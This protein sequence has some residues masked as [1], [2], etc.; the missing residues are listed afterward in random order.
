MYLYILYSP[1]LNRYYKGVSDHPEQ[2]LVE[3][4]TAI[5][6]SAYTAAASDWEL[7]FQLK[8]ENKTQALKIERYLKKSAN[9]NYLKRF[10]TDAE[11]Q[12]T[13]LLKFRD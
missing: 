11:L 2:R 13:I 1:K 5:K 8:C 6:A 9:I 10:M 12:N 4:N 7:V 3:H